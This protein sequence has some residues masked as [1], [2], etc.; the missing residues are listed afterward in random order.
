MVTVK[1]AVS[2]RVYFAE[3]GRDVIG[4]V[5][6]IKPISIANGTELKLNNLYKVDW[7]NGYP[8]GWYVEAQLEK[9]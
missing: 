8:S 2:D 5:V 1:F 9:V 3:N 7:D 4:L 6:E